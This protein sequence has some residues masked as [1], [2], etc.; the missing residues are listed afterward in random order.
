MDENAY[1]NAVAEDSDVVRRLKRRIA[2]LEARLAS[3]SWTPITPGN[4]PKVGDE[5]YGR[6]SS[7]EHYVFICTGKELPEAWAASICTHFRALNPP[8]EHPAPET[9]E[10]NG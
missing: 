4:L 10:A 6:Y 7:G 9:G 3:L 8:S 5:V 1:R 2:E